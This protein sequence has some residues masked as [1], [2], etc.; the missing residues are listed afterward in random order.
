MLAVMA[1]EKKGRSGGSRVM[2]SGMVLKNKKTNRINST[3]L[4]FLFLCRY[5]CLHRKLRARNGVNSLG[6]GSQH[7]AGLIINF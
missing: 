4:F 7:L 6:I 5:I 2:G 3:N 1:I